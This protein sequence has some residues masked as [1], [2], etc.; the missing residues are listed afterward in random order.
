[1]RNIPHSQTLN[2]LMKNNTT[3]YLKGSRTFSSRIPSAHNIHV[4]GTS[5]L[6]NLMLTGQDDKI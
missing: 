1:M 3:F 4:L 2:M 6:V 5:R